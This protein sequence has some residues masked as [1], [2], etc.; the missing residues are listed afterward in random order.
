MHH[1]SSRSSPSDDSGNLV[2]QFRCCCP[3]CLWSPWC[4]VSTQPALQRG[5]KR[6]DNCC[7]VYGFTELMVSNEDIII[8][9]NGGNFHISHSATLAEWLS[10]WVAAPATLAE[11]LS[12]W[13]EQPLRQSG[14]V[15]EWLRQSHQSMKWTDKV[16]NISI[17][18]QEYMTLTATWFTNITL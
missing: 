8:R 14:W 2:V 10:V 4:C 11:W 12:G 17:S 6:W 9:Y 5:K 1:C 3:A 15:A 7:A 16:L 13:V 18:K